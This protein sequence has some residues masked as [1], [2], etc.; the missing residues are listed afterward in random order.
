MLVSPEIFTPFKNVRAAQST[1]LGGY[2][3][4]P[5]ESLNLGKSVGDDPEIV[6]KNRS[7]FFNDLGFENHQIALSHQVH[8]NEVLLVEKP[9]NYTG[10][11]AQ[12][13]NKKNIGLAV[14]IAD[15]T[16]IL[17]YDAE[18]E[19]VAAIHAGWKGTVGQI[20][21]KALAA[22]H[23]NYGTKGKNCYAYIGACIS[24]E[25]FE[26]NADVADFF[27]ENFK[28]YDAKKNKFYVNLK[29]ANKAQLIDFGVPENQIEIS[30]FC[31]VGDNNLFFSHRKE[32]GKTG[33]TLALIG[34]KS[35]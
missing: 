27:T 19:A 25:N 20:V 8:G 23:E 2:S 9:G 6:E 4:T 18:N 29:A 7:Q 24:Y 32:Q 10:F 35:D 17:I 26:V 14:S 11:D 1:R 16:P 5:F 28:K 33:R 21:T 31:T 34:I 30:K 15:C 22:M 12:I 3:L 13:T